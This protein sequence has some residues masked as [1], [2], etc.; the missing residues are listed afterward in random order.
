MTTVL[1]VSDLR[2]QVG[3]SPVWSVAEQAL[4]W[5]DIEGRQIRRYDWALRS[6]QSWATDERIGSIVL[7]EGGGLVAG[8]ESGVFEI[9]LP[10]GD[11]HATERLLFPMTFRFLGEFAGGEMKFMPR[12]GEY[13]TFYSWFLLGLGAVFQLPVVIFVM[14]R[15]GLV[16]AGFLLRQFKYAVLAAFVLSATMLIAACQS[17][18]PFGVWTVHG[19]IRVPSPSV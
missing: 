18:Q 11:P 8:M 9:D 10:A 4:Y 12:I 19:P 5:V 15:I 14:A 6:V 3:E 16:S 13:Y 1:A 17:D 7:R 2:D